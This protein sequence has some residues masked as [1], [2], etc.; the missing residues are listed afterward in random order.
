MLVEQM[1]INLLRNACEA[2]DTPVTISLSTQRTSDLIKVCV[3]DDG[4]GF[5][6]DGLQG[7][8]RP[9]RTMKKEGF[10]LGLA[11][12]RTIVEALGGELAIRA[13]Q[14]QGASVSF[15]IPAAPAHDDPLASE[16]LGG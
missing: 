7:L 14:D 3:E 12:C 4:P 2:T 10:G 1:F 16:S 15:T 11:I 5:E 13:A 8:F 6:Y 9:L